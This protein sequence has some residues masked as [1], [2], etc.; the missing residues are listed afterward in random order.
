MKRSLLLVL[1]FL[2]AGS[3]LAFPPNQCA[4][5]LKYGIYDN[6]NVVDSNEKF[7]RTKQAYCNSSSSDWG[8]TIPIE[9]VP[10]EGNASF[11]DSACGNSDSTKYESYYLYKSAQVINAD[12]VR[13]FDECLRVGNPGLTYTVKTT[14]DPKLF[15]IDF[16]FVRFGKIVTDRIKVLIEGATCTST[17]FT[18]R[19]V[20]GET[21]KLKISTTLSMSCARKKEDTVQIAVEST[22]GQVNTESVTLPGWKPKIEPTSFKFIAPQVDKTPLDMCPSWA[23]NCNPG[24]VNGKAAGTLWCNARQLGEA[25]DVKVL[26]DA[27]PT[28][29]ITDGRLCNEPTCDRITELTCAA[30]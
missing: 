4:E 24:G 5:L 14:G 15:N 27:P 3:A 21:R 6:F 8:V 17:Q 2:W 22:R 12:I 11:K 30:N 13:G 19:T 10:A 1:Y 20:S 7:E 28:R 9:G 23:N 29:I 25:I 18:G 26:M 16:T